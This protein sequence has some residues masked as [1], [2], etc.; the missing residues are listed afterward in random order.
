M[1]VGGEEPVG[2][3]PKATS[4][5]ATNQT[6]YADAAAVKGWAARNPPGAWLI[7]AT[8]PAL[9][10][11]HP[12]VALVKDMISTGEAIPA[13]GRGAGGLLQYRICRARPQLLAE[14]GQV[15]GTSRL[16]LDPEFAET[17]AGR[18]LQLLSR[19]A[20]LG[21]PTPSNRELAEQTGLRDAEAARY[22]LGLLVKAGHLT[23][24]TLASGARVVTI[25]ATGRS[26]PERAAGERGVPVAD[27]SLKC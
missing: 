1:G 27:G 18:I 4:A 14:G 2:M 13:Q 26:T 15:R 10:P 24:R 3:E 11:R 22:Q 23:A 6:L 25:R 8:G 5:L 21:L 16:R 9:D 12:T 20:N 7:Y 19:P 17:P